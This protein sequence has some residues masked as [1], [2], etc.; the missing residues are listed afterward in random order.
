MRIGGLGLTV[1]PNVQPRTAIVANASTAIRRHDA[2]VRAQRMPSLLPN[3]ERRQGARALLQVIHRHQVGDTV[4]RRVS[5]LLYVRGKPVAL[6]DWINLGGVRTPLYTYPLD[7]LKL[8]AD[9]ARRGVFHYDDLTADPRFAPD[10]AAGLSLI[11][12]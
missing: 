6:I 2:C 7:P 11:H 10:G 9:V 8:R 1:Q 3:R 4:F 12:I 5:E